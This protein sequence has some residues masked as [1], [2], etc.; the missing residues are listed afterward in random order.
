[1]HLIIHECT[2]QRERKLDGNLL[3]L[4]REEANCGDGTQK[5]HRKIFPLVG[6]TTLFYILI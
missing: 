5:G 6:Q 4:L 1:M 3:G 2:G